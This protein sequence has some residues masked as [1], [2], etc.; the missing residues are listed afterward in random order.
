M[1][2]SQF[3]VHQIL[4]HAPR[5]LMRSSTLTVYDRAFGCEMQEVFE[6]DLSRSRRYTLEDFEKRSLWERLVE[7]VMLPFHSQV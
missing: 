3:S 1:E 7:W 4:T 6:R 2:S 5:R